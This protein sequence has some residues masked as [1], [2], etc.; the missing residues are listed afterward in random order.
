MR[1]SHRQENADMRTD[2]NLEAKCVDAAQTRLFLERELMSVYGCVRLC[3]Y[4][5]TFT[6]KHRDTHTLS[7]HMLVVD[8]ILA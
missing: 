3:I 6:H 7:T 8:V 5:H 1:R 2:Q 4:T